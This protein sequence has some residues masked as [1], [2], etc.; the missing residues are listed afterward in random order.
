M[1]KRKALKKVSRKQSEVSCGINCSGDEYQLP[2][3][4]HPCDYIMEKLSCGS[5]VMW[6]CFSNE[7]PFENLWQYIKIAVYSWFPSNQTWLEL[8]C[9][10]E[11]AINFGRKGRSMVGK[12]S[13]CQCGF[14]TFIFPH[15]VRCL[16][17]THC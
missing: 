8:F 13:S 15:T 2:N 11:C 7:N 3:H 10:K 4:R 5:I 16:H 17:D 14:K 12:K 6:G 9:E 1:A